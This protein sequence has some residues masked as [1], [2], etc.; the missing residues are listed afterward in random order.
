MV[1]VGGGIEHPPEM[2]DR[3]PRIARADEKVIE[4]TQLLRG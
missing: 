2:R 1:F 3:V 4:S